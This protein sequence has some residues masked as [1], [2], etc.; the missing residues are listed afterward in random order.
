MLNPECP[1][2]GG[3]LCRANYPPSSRCTTHGG[4]YTCIAGEDYLCLYATTAEE[5]HTLSATRRDATPT[6]LICL[7]TSQ[8][9]TASSGPSSGGST[10]ASDITTATDALPEPSRVGLPSTGVADSKRKRR[11]RVSNRLLWIGGALI[12]A[13]LI[14]GAAEGETLS[15]IKQVPEGA[16]IPADPCFR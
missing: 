5:D 4:R 15:M 2:A 1:R 3:F 16:S 10:S 14:V 6:S 8:P 11:S 12:L 9:A 13:A 7:S